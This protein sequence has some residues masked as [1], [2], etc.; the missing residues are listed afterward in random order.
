MSGHPLCTARV[1]GVWCSA[2]CGNRTACYE[3]KAYAMSP[4]ARARL[5][6]FL[7]I[8]RELQREPTNAELAGLWGVTV[9]RVKQLRN[10]WERKGELPPRS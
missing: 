1:T 7:A 3:H 9:S 4:E 8:V 6:S 5:E 10:H 2:G